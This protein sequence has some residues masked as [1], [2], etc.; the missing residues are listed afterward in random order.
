MCPVV[1]SCDGVQIKPDPLHLPGGF[2]PHINEIQQAVSPELL[3]QLMD[4]FLLGMIRRI[5]G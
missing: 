4:L 2:G 5:V 3:K 1:D